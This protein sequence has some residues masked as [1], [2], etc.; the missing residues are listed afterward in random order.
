MLKPQYARFL[1]ALSSLSPEQIRNLLYII[2][3]ISASIGIVI[4]NKILFKKYDFPFGTLLTAVHFI[5]TFLGLELCA[6][7][8]VFE[9]KQLPIRQIYG[10]SAS[11]CGFVVL[12]NLSLVHNSVGFYQLAKVMTTPAI[13]LIQTASYNMV[14]P[15]AI[16]SSL[17]IICVGVIIA[18]VTDVELNFLGSFYAVSGVIVTSY[19]QIWVGTKQKELNANSMQ[20]LYYQAPL[21]TV[22]LIPTIPFFDDM[23]LLFSYSWNWT[24]VFIILLTGALAF[25]VN[26]SIFLV[27]GRTSP[28]TYNIVGHF[29]LCLILVLGFLIFGYPL[30][31]KNIS[32]I[33][34]TLG[35]I[36]YYTH[37]KLSGKGN[38]ITTT[39]PSTRSPS[40]RELDR[41]LL[42]ERD[43]G[44][45]L[46]KV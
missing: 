33:F 34:V 17:A 42:L 25:A 20:L 11:F 26:V 23:S 22:M 5:V 28:V 36:F 24:V 46:E 14:F 13:V 19:Y 16:K 44:K 10:L 32:G 6:R 3:N 29:K 7:F 39:S 15:S 8:G 41:K 40:D 1:G 30:N 18:S 45:V 43:E 4:V 37:L 35:G 9:R 31:V 2:L 38:V 12:T 27:V 21:S